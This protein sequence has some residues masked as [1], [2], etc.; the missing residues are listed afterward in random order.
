MTP[1]PLA[2]ALLAAG[3]IVFGP[4]AAAAGRA[5]VIG[6]RAPTDVSSV[7]TGI[8]DAGQVV[9]Q[10]VNR[11]GFASAFLFTGGAMQDLGTLAAPYNYVSAANGLNA[12]GLV[13]GDSWLSFVTPRAFLNTGGV[14][15]DLG[16]LGGIKSYANGINAAGQ[17]VGSAETGALDQHAYRWTNGVMQDLGTLGGRFSAA[18]A[19]NA[20]GQVVG[21]SSRATGPEH[22]FLYSG[23]TMQDLGT[24]IV[25]GTS[26]ARAINDSGWVVGTASKGGIPQ[27]AF[28]YANGVM[29][30]LGSLAGG[31]SSALGINA[32]G[33]I[34]GAS[35]V[36]SNEGQVSHAFLHNA[37]TMFDLN[38]VAPAGWVLR[39]AAGINAYA[40]ITGTGVLSS[41]NSRDQAYRLT[42]HPDW[43][44]GN[45]SWSDASRWNYAGMGAFGI[46]PGA[47]HDVLINP[48][49]SATVFGPVDA[50][51][52]RLTVQAANGQIAT[53]N[54]ARGAIYAQNGSTLGH[55]GTLTGSGR[56]AG[57]LLIQRGGRVLVRDNEA[58]QLAGAVENLGSIDVQATTGRATLEVGGPLSNAGS[59]N[60]MN[61]DLAAR[62]GI[63][64]NGRISIAGTTSIYGPVTNGEN[65]LISVSGIASHGMFWGDFTN[66]GSFIVTAGSTATFFNWVGGIGSFDGAG[67]K[68]FANGYAPGNSAALVALDGSVNFEA[69]ALAMELGGTAAGSGHDKLVFGGPVALGGASLQVLW[70]DGWAGQ[71]GDHFDLFDWN[72]SPAGRF[73]SIRLPT[74]AAGLA[75]NSS[76][77][78]TSGELSITAVPEPGNWAL[79]AAGLGVLGALGRR[80]SLREI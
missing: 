15:R 73:A 52:N 71:A 1:T 76:Q 67:T 56:L 20:S 8:N 42:L 37:G 18:T 45:G 61:A 55:N 44:G 30:D 58:M 64:N 12:S 74:L 46:T 26:E 25:G 77:L 16:A 27:G 6:L 51:V 2:R 35:F 65:S 57:D 28:L 23:T 41:Q 59:L 36:V 70:L 14:M 40:Q 79:M 62:G 3:L 4:W 17:V 75:W 19:I 34:V 54:L 31:S 43:Q 10:K 29:Q 32:T 78:Y 7:G 33:Q 24:L 50:T 80:R 5:D 13:V 66:E 22:A 63:T 72:G 48:I 68:N 53:L 38:N 47:P 9:G 60:L 49:G 21:R 11:F 69:G 39:D